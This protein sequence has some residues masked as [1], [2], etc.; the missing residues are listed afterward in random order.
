V[1]VVHGTVAAPPA[2]SGAEEDDELPSHQAGSRALVTARFDPSVMPRPGERLA[3]GVDPSK[4]H[5][6]DAATGARL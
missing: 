3:V 4:T 1:V 5:V 6:F 2:L